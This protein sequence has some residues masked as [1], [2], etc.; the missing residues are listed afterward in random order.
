M[1]WVNDWPIMGVDGET[2]VTSHRKP[3]VGRTYSPATP[4]ES[5]EFNDHRFNLQWQWSANPQSNWAFPAAAYGF[6]RLLNVPA[7]KDAKNFG[8]FLISC[9]KSSRLR[10]SL[11][12]PKLPSPAKRWRTNRTNRNGSRLR[13]PFRREKTRRTLHL[14]DSLSERGQRFARKRDGRIKTRQ[15]HLL[16]TRKSRGKCGLQFQL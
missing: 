6:L 14:A 8:T 11:P 15:Q 9:S 3:N 7:P 10:H 16:A 2:V 13:L 1:K 5:D 4:A 12:P